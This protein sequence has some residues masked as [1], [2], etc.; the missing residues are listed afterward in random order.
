MFDAVGKVS[1][2]LVILQSLPPRGQ[3]LKS[4]FKGRL[5]VGVVDFGPLLALLHFL[6]FVQFADEDYEFEEAEEG[7]TPEYCTSH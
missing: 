1:A 5:V 3:D 2:K 4:P 7:P 6:H